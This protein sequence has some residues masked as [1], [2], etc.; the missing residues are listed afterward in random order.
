[1]TAEDLFVSTDYPD[2]TCLY[3]NQSILHQ[4]NEICDSKQ[5]GEDFFFKFSSEKCIQ[6]LV[7]RVSKAEEGI[8]L[9]WF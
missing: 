2:T 3:K 8:Y 5:F 9:L 6:W 4:L 1:M 7:K